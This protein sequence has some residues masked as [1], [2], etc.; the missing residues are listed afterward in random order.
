MGQRFGCSISLF[1]KSAV[2]IKGFEG[3][4]K[5]EQGFSVRHLT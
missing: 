3:V 5:S 1:R 4:L 2:K